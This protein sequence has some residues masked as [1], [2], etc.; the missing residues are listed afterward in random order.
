MKVIR[1]QGPRGNWEMAFAGPSRP[2][3]GLVDTYIGYDERDTA[4][5][6]RHELPGLFAVL[7]VNLGEPITIIDTAGYVIPVRSGDGFGAGLSE[8][9]AVS[10]SSGS[11]RGFQVMFTPL[12]ARRFFG[13]PLHH[14]ANRVFS[15][16]DLLGAAR[17]T[18]LIDGLQAANDWATGFRHLDAAILSR[19]ATD[20]D[21]DLA[22]ARQTAWALRRLQQEGGRLSIAALADE[23][24]CSR[25]HLAVGFREHVGIAPKTVARLLRFRQ[26]L[27]LVDMAERVDWS[28]IAQE[29]GYADQSH[30]SND[31]RQ[32]T[33]RSPGAYLA[34]RLPDQVGLPVG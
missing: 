16:H 1:Q 4:F 29:A 32:I 27:Q 13:L 30:F 31:F 26:V 11:Q 3:A 2:L 15:L 23:V 8:A 34:L 5:T 12:G 6:R 25:K 28:A 19:L 33:G 10:E 22:G 9:Y 21:F 7:I 20:A 24:G 18:A 17:A 14:L